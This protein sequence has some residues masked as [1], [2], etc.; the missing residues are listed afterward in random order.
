MTSHAVEPTDTALVYMSRGTSDRLR[1]PDK[2]D[3]PTTLIVWLKD[4][5]V[6]DA[7]DAQLD[8]EDDDE[9]NG[10]VIP[11]LSISQ[12]DNHLVFGNVTKKHAGKY[13]CTAYSP[14]GPRHKTHRFSVVVKG[15]CR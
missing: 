8:D 5:R 2:A 9:R 6:I 3:P 4:G 1:C 14:L 7:T 10:D 13:A 12:H 11:R 15:L